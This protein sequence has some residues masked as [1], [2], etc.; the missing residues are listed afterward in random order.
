VPAR[1]GGALQRSRAPVPWAGTV[2]LVGSAV[3]VN[4]HTDTSAAENT[5]CDDITNAGTV[6]LPATQAAAVDVLVDGA[7]ARLGSLSYRVPA[8]LD[9]SVGDAVEVPFG[10]RPAASGLV[11]G[12]GDPLKATRDVVRVWGQRIHPGDLAVAASI[13][14]RH[15][16]NL[17]A[18][19]SR[20]APRDGKGDAAVDAGECALAP[21]AVVDVGDMVANKYLL[22]SPSTSASRLAAGAAARLAADGQVLVLCPTRALAKAVAASFTSGAALLDEPGAWSGFRSGTVTVGVGTRTAA[23]WSPQVLAGIVV[24]EEDHPGHVEARLPYTNARDVAV[25][26]AR[27]RGVPVTLTGMCPT[28]AG[29]GAGVKAVAVGEALTLTV[30][31]ASGRALP[32]RALAAVAT[33]LRVGR[34]VVVVAPARAARRACGTCRVTRPCTVCDQPGCAHGG[35]AACERCGSVEVRRVGWDPVRVAAALP[36]G[37]KVVAPGETLKGR[38]D[39][40]VVLDADGPARRPGLEPDAAVGR[41]LLHA[42]QTHLG[43][44]G[45]LLAVADDVEHP[46]LVALG[47]SSV[48]LA[49]LVWA[50]AKS[51]LLPPFGRLVSVQ[52]AAPKPPPVT[53][54]PGQV[55][56]PRAGARPGEWEILVR[57]SDVDLDA[58]RP[59]LAR[60]IRRCKVRITIT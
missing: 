10:K 27:A 50:G 36:A 52:V 37:V 11:V 42:A 39:L 24:V 57:C 41:A 2:A 46:A 17:A 3:S 32:G 40:L 33:A 58:L 19:A 29:L 22:R 5:A 60:L 7:P 34:D 54:W 51:A 23:L 26:R 35:T 44:G 9:V 25:A 1:S 53:G 18:V 31:P 38:C 14:E 43:P 49:K 15:M 4:E 45:E 6:A 59:H 56:G 16:S 13:A 12:P 48:A 30:V 28:G 20:L 55:L 8:A 47:E 21:G